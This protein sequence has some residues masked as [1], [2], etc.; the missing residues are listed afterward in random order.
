MARSSPQPPFGAGTS[1]HASALMSYR[2]ITPSPTTYDSGPDLRSI[3]TICARSAVV[4]GSI[5][6]ISSVPLASATIVPFVPTA[7]VLLPTYATER[8]S[9]FTG[10]STRLRPLS[11]TITPPSPTPTL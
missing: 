8:R 2:S 3:V 11:S 1:D 6:A 9:A 7:T 10:R 5:T 4:P